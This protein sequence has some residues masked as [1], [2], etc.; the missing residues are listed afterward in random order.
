M[1]STVQQNKE[2]VRMITER[3]FNDGDLTGISDFFSPDYRVHAPGVPDLPPGPK[4][5]ET[6]VTLWLDGFPDLR[7]TIEDL[8]GEDDRVYARFTTRGTHTGALF[9]VIPPTG[10]SVTVHEMSCHRIENGKVVESWIGDNVPSIL[11]Q[12]GVSAPAH[13][14]A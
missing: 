4:S 3:G 5:F 7:V 2:L 11:H 13:G 10:R 6:A 8:V 1:T 12:L 9:G 14:E